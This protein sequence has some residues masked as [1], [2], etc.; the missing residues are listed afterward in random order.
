MQESQA[1]QNLSIPKGFRNKKRDA[2]GIQ[3]ELSVNAKGSF[4]FFFSLLHKAAHDRGPSLKRMRINSVM[5]SYES[6]SMQGIW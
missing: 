1:R 4:F 5:C 6:S 2:S 3:S